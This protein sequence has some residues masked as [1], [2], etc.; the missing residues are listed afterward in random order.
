MRP[1]D[2]QLLVDMVQAA[3]TMYDPDRYG[4]LAARPWRYYRLPDGSHT[5]ADG[6]GAAF[7]GTSLP[8][9]VA[10]MICWL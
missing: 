2:G 7:T 5:V 3:L 8:K 9:T 10:E 6:K 4:H 1:R